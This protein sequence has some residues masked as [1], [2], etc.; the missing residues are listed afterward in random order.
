MAGAL[1]CLQSRLQSAWIKSQ[2]WP[3]DCI[4]RLSNSGWIW[5]PLQSSFWSTCCYQ[6]ANWRIDK[7]HWFH[8]GLGSAFSSFTAAQLALDPLPDFSTLLARAHSH[9]L[10]QKSLDDSHSS[11]ADWCISFIFGCYLVS[12]VY[13]IAVIIY[14]SMLYSHLFIKENY[15]SLTITNRVRNQ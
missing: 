15:L 12:L 8:R 2:R 4:T 14:Y 11:Q 7:S 13:A 5:S 6:P 3:L 9:E 10:F 1:S